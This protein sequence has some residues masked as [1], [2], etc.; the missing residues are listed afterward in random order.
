MSRS[1]LVAVVLLA[2]LTESAVAQEGYEA[3][4]PAPV[5]TT[6][7]WSAE[8][9]VL[10][11]ELKLTADQIKGMVA[12]RQ[13]WWDFYYTASPKEFNTRIADEDKALAAAVAALFSADQLTRAQ[14]L[15]A[16]INLA[17]FNTG[18]HE[19]DGITRTVAVPDKFDLTRVSG[20]ALHYSPE[21]AAA[22]KL[23]DDQKKLVTNGSGWGSG[24]NG[25][26]LLTPDQTAAARAY[27]GPI[28]RREWKT[29]EDPRVA[30]L[31]TGDGPSSVPGPLGLVQARD[32]RKAADITEDQ[33][34]AL[35]PTY[36]LWTKFQSENLSP[37]KTL[38]RR[39]E[40]NAESDS[41]LA[42]VLKP[43]QLARVKQ[44]EFQLLSVEERPGV[45]QFAHPTIEK[46]LGFTVAQQKAYEAAYKECDE[47]VARA[48]RAGGGL[49]ATDKAI[50]AATAARNKAVDSILTDE[51]VKKWDTLRG[52]PFVGSSS[53]DQLGPS[54]RGGFGGP[55]GFGGSGN[56][57]SN[58]VFKELSFGRYAL[59]LSYLSRNESI[60]TELKLTPEQ[61]KKAGAA[62]QD[63][64][65]KFPT[66][67]LNN[68]ADVEKGTKSHEE[69][70]KFVE[71]ALGEVLTA[72]QAKRFRQIM[73]QDR[74]RSPYSAVRPV[75]S[76]V[77]YPGVADAVK[78]TAE[79]KKKLIEGT[80]PA[81]VLTDEQKA[82]VKAT[83]GEAFN[84][85]FSTTKGGNPWAGGTAPGGFP[86]TAW[87]PSVI[88]PELKVVRELTFGRYTLEL[89]QLSRNELIQTELKLTPEQ[90]KKAVAAYQDQLQKFPA[91]DLNLARSDPPK[92]AKLY[93]ERS[94]LVEKALGEILTA[95]QAK[96]FRQVAIQIRE[97]PA[98]PFGADLTTVSSAASYPGVAEAV[99]LTAEQKKK[100][101]DGTAPANVLTD[102][103]KAAVKDLRGDPF[104]GASAVAAPSGGPWGNPGTGGM[105][106][107]GGG[108]NGGMG[109]GRVQDPEQS[110]AM[111]QRVTSD[112]GDTIDLGKIPSQTHAL[113]KSMTERTGGI[114][115]PETGVMTKAAYLEYHAKNE[116]ARAEANDQL[117]TGDPARAREWTFGRYTNEL[118]SLVRHE[119]IRTELKLTPEQVKKV[120]A[121]YQEL[122][123]A[124]SLATLKAADA[125]AA[126]ERWFEGRSKAIEKALADV[127]TPEQS[128]RFRQITL[129]LR[130]RATQVLGFHGTVPSA[131]ACPEVGEAVKLTAEQKK[132]LIEGGAAAVVLT[133]EQKAAVQALLGEPFKDAATV[134][135]LPNWSGGGMSSPGGFSG[136]PWR[137]GL[138]DRTRLTTVLPWD[139]LK[140]TP[141][142]VAKLATVFN[143]YHAASTRSPGGRGGNPF[144]VQPKT[145]GPEVA[146]DKDVESILTSDQ[147]KRLDQLIVQSRAATGLLAVLS[148]PAGVPRL[149]PEQAKQFAAD[150]Q[151][152][153]D[154]ARFVEDAAL[155]QE[156]STEL[157]RALRDRLDARILDALTA[158][159][160]AA[161]KERTG[162]AY[163]GF[164]KPPLAG[165][166]ST[167]WGPR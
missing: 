100:L 144:A 93:E 164:V 109:G 95:D 6:L 128:K 129:Q 138:T 135:P 67:E 101:I 71:K 143:R 68:F 104:K 74:E 17:Q 108:M 97:Q 32:V 142:Q 12:A 55:G 94:K 76:A 139:A 118:G 57:W 141:D 155:S 163:A 157:R 148:E 117:T 13:K 59:E 39:K 1:H 82:A 69:R 43:E 24:F 45:V 73:L 35:A 50:K 70:S 165:R 134:L 86:G 130:E 30:D 62:Y 28:V 49:E 121:A 34:K 52:A 66:G 159:Q 21:F 137:N 16:Q 125:D 83:L 40:L 15:A 112:S 132:K 146:V 162:A 91:R 65:Q 150:G 37:E 4:P 60:Q 105:G 123:K 126:R 80:A 98:Q 156:R 89:S 158:E 92:A 102:E 77:S 110:W 127:L 136:N 8:D 145:D 27:L 90:L 87:T 116:T 166:S 29:T 18:P 53:P 122:L 160:K 56:P 11:K 75:P 81:G 133:A 25:L 119:V 26:V 41:A 124:F 111:L 106:G 63:Q 107:P 9:D 31:Y 161:W 47:V 147:L 78:L 149:T 153:A 54:G 5:I 42:R 103:Q 96:R 38:R 120:G 79:Q 85:T 151:E 33:F 154:V 36:E 51:Q 2:A 114:A 152:L 20:T 61:I 19:R 88:T 3:G 44:I 115:L 99:K 84:G 23:T 140:L 64:L 58:P 10:Q 131:V 113:L 7:V 22:L 167:G 72:E 48:V 14:Q 46:A